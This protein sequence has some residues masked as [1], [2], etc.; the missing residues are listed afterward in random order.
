[1]ALPQK[2]LFKLESTRSDMVIPV[3]YND[4]GAIDPGPD[5]VFWSQL[6]VDQFLAQNGATNFKHINSVINALPLNINHSVTLNLAKGIHRPRPEDGGDYVTAGIELN[7]NLNA[8][9]IFQGAAPSEWDPVDPTLVDLDVDGAQVGSDDPWLDFSTTNPGVFAGFDL[10]GMGVVLSTGQVVFIHDHDDEKLYVLQELSPSPIGETVTIATP[11]TVF[12]NADPG[13]LDYVCWYDMTVTVPR[14][15]HK[16]GYVRVNDVTFLKFKNY[17][18]ITVNSAKFWGNRLLVDAKTH[19]A[20]G[21]AIVAYNGATA[22]VYPGSLLAKAP[23]FDPQDEALSISDSG[24]Y[25]YGVFIQGWEN[26]IQ[27]LDG[28]KALFFSTVLNSVTRSSGT[29]LVPQLLWG[30]ASIIVVDAKVY[31]GILGAG[32]ACEIRNSRDGVA[33]VSFHGSGK[34]TPRYGNTPST[35]E[36]NYVIFKN[37]GGPCVRIGTGVS[38]ALIHEPT[39]AAYTRQRWLDGGGNLDVGF[40]LNGPGSSVD[41]DFEITATGA[42]GDVRMAGGIVPYTDLVADGPYE[43]ERGSVA[44]KDS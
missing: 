15:M 4:A 42:N 34:N 38:L 2:E 12:K 3:D 24:L 6:S 32:K 29:P 7:K 16:T 23:A 30:D 14:G 36:E 9:F 28:S 19:D 27:I 33:G 35:A 22:V 25:A 41:L 10:K 20:N 13:D 40:E 5:D 44:K 37:M 43:D 11:S 21:S 26:G 18:G 31:F 1:M 39:G 17:N 8:D